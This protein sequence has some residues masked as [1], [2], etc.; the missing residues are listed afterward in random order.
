MVD[1]GADLL[2]QASGCVRQQPQP[3]PQATTA[4]QMSQLPKET[5]SK[6]KQK[7]SLENKS[8]IITQSNDQQR[9]RERRSRLK[10]LTT[11]CQD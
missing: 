2:C 5:K 4:A 11:T 9:D 6:L 7:D 10:R 1:D 8:F 3:Q